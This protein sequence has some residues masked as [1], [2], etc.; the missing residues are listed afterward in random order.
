MSDISRFFDRSLKLS[1]LRLLVMFAQHGQ[2]R[3]VAD[4]LNVSQPAVSKQLAELERGVGAAILERTGNRLIFTALGEALLKRA[5]EVL[6][7]LEHARQDVQAVS[8]GLRGKLNIGAVATVFQSMAPQIVL[9][10]KRSSPGVSVALSQATSDQLF[11]QL[12]NGTIDLLLCRTVPSQLASGDFVCKRLLDDPIVITCS[13][14]H[15]LATRQMLTPQD[16]AGWSWILPPRTSPAF[17]A[18]NSWMHEHQLFFPDG[19]IES[20]SM[21]VNHSLMTAYPFLSV[22]PLS[23]MHKR[24]MGAELVELGLPD[25]RFLGHVWI[26]YNRKPDRPLVVTALE[27]IEALIAQ[28]AF[29]VP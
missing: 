22:M 27:K 13:N 3:L 25:A 18:L 1:H 4:Q 24:M 26:I 5:R 7:Q 14:S 12:A 15:P 20:I 11:P 10:M 9:E 23:F 21:S 29:D 17:L 19:C 6:Y 2:L 8:D 28:G 16:L